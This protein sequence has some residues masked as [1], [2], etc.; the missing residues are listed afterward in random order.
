VNKPDLKTMSKNKKK[1]LKKKE[2]QKQKMLELTQQQIQVNFIFLVLKFSKSCYHFKDAE[3]QKQ[4]LL[5]SPNQINL[6]KISIT[7]EVE[8]SPSNGY[9]QNS[10]DESDDENPDNEQL[11]NE[12]AALAAAAVVISGD[13]NKQTDS[14]ESDPINR[15]MLLF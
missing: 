8:L 1:K 5:N 13:E 7:D 12:Q 6:N 9:K 2:K 3:K 11:I 15:R 14:N 10:L 4:N